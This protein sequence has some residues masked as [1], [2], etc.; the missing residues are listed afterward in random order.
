MAGGGDT[1]YYA[2]SI[3]TDGVVEATVTAVHQGQ[4]KG[5]GAIHSH[6]YFEKGP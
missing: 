5:I 4:P 1:F 6:R 3:V 2:G